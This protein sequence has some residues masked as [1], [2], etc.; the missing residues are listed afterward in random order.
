MDWEQ[1]RLLKWQYNR[2]VMVKVCLICLVS[3]GQ[4]SRPLGAKGRTIWHGCKNNLVFESYMAELSRMIHTYALVYI[5]LL[6]MCSVC[7]ALTR[8]KCYS[9]WTVNWTYPIAA[10][11][12]VRVVSVVNSRDSARRSRTVYRERIS[13]PAATGRHARMASENS[14]INVPTAE[15][16]GTHVYLKEFYEQTSTDFNGK[17][18]TLLC[19]LCPPDLRKLVRTSASSTANLKRH[20]RLKHPDSLGKYCDLMTI[21]TKRVSTWA[22]R[23]VPPSQTDPVCKGW[24]LRF[25]WFVTLCIIVSHPC[26]VWQV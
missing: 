25:A 20:I 2:I 4:L 24:W 6:C 18:H 7:S 22:K 16:N 9:W 10:T 19:K 14:N 12:R 3:V 5:S 23:K 11:E 1:E 26:I 17:N 8:K 21:I 15:G 13:F